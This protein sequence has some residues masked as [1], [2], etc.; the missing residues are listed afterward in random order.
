VSETD[1]PRTGR[2]PTGILE[3]VLR[4]SSGFSEA[5]RRWLLEALSGLEPH[6]PRRDPGSMIVDV[7]VKHRDGK[8][9]Q[10][11]L[12]AELPGHPPLVAKSA[13]RNLARALAEAKRELIRQIED[14][15]KK[16]EPKSN[17]LLRN[18]TT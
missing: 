5:D 2:S 8:E 3:D 11:T 7:S 18:K 6:L 17:R 10:I 14:E 15:K 13:D 1:D 16:L 9:Q 12:R 4:L